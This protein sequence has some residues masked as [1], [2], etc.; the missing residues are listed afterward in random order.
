M[1]SF[2]DGAFDSAG[3]FDPAAWDFGSPVIPVL[4]GGHFGFD[5]KKRKRRFDEELGAEQA[6]K[7]A[8]QKAFGLLPEPVQEQV[9]AE[10]AQTTEK[11][12]WTPIAVD[13]ARY[14]YAIARIESRLQDIEEEQELNELIQMG[15]L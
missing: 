8:L 13:P 7:L 5:E 2:S 9:A 3:A 4:T 15:L 10:V 1:A 12:D 6:R 14:A 11:I